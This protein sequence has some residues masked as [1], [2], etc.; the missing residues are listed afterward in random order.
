MRIGLFIV[1][2][3]VSLSMFGIVLGDQS[4]SGT[5]EP[6]YPKN[7]PYQDTSQNV[8]ET[9]YQDPGIAEPYYPA[10]PPVP[11]FAPNQ[12]PVQVEPLPSPSSDPGSAEP[13]YPTSPPQPAPTEYIPPVDH[14]YRE[15][16]S[17][18]S[19]ESVVVHN[20]YDYR[21]YRPPYDE[22]Y[23]RRWDWYSY[24]D[25]SLRF[26]ALRIRQKYTWTTDSEVYA[27]LRVS[28]S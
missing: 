1:I 25:E 14:S 26:Q 3:C 18:P 24:S 10:T 22:I 13:Y 7:L 28:Y 16:Y 5:A 15:Y 6:F 17:L 8:I 11:S 21:D 27:V 9:S 2:V 20:W 19:H 23:D 4:G 12:E